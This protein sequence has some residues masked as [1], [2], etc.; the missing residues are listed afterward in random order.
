MLLSFHKRIIISLLCDHSDLPWP[1]F[2]CLWSSQRPLALERDGLV[3]QKEL[4]DP[5]HKRASSL[6]S[7][8]G[9]SRKS[10]FPR[11]LTGA[12]T[13]TQLI[14]LVQLILARSS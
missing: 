11:L 14:M 3:L 13:G 2:P 6:L 10:R 9:W 4:S 8:A 7:A 5:A 12:N 1:S